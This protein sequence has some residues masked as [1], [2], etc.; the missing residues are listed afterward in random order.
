MRVKRGCSSLSRYIVLFCVLLLQITPFAAANNQGFVWGLEAGTRL[1]YREIRTEESGSETRTLMDEEMYII[2][3][4]LPD[5]PDDIDSIGPFIPYNI[6]GSAY[7]K[8]GSAYPY[9]IGSFSNFQVLPI[10]NWP[11]LTSIFGENREIFQDSEMWG[12]HY[13]DNRENISGESDYQFLKADGALAYVYYMLY[14]LTSDVR[15][16]VEI[17]R[18]GYSKREPTLFTPIF[19]MAAILGIVGL[20]VII[21]VFWRR[22][23]RSTQ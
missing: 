22:R 11:L 16:S 10:G 8:N 14:N 9:V 1:D 20:P 2:T 5:I 18:E 19:W 21:L 17:T 6:Q 3:D 23:I 4:E 12:M 13:S 7:W 15:W